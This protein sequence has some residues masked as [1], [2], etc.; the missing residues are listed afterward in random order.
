MQASPVSLL[1][2]IGVSF[3]VSTKSLNPHHYQLLVDRGWRRLPVDQFKPRRDQRQAVNRW[4]K[5]VLGDEYLKH[6]AK[7]HPK[8]KEEKARRDE[9]SLIA[10]VHE[11]EF[12]SVKLPPEPAHKFEVSLEADDFTNEKFELYKNYQHHVHHDALG[13][14]SPNGFKRFL[15]N[16]PLQRT[17]SSGYLPRKLG[18]FHQCYRLDGRLIA[19]AV[20]DLLP[21]CVSGVYFVYHSDFEQ[22]SFGK[23]SALREASLA[24]EEGYRYYYMGYYIHSCQ[25]MRYKNDYKP[26]MVLDL[27]DLTWNLLDDQFLA[28][29]NQHHY[30]EP[31]SLEKKDS[32]KPDRQCFDSAVAACEAV[33][34]G[35]SLFNVDF[36]G[37]MSASELVEQIDLQKI[38]VQLRPDL[39]LHTENL[40]DWGE[41]S[42]YASDPK[43]LIAQIAACV[44]P[45][46]AREMVI[47]F[48]G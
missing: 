14:I 21:H 5:Y 24:L 4:N 38:T 37:M 10:T 11:S 25:K 17:S 23:I 42:I 39:V 29:L 12:V 3:Y 8:S 31:S 30:L 2:P 22:W 13:S 41:W 44:G 6:A 33:D 1:T 36:P 15:C 20:L 26:Q 16:S 48:S 28:L 34:D 47:S 32:E 35:L 18:S 45:E 27:A 7:L 40:M 9:F 43:G 46:V 19:M